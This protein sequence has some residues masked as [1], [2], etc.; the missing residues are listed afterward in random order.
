MPISWQLGFATATGFYGQ[1]ITALHNT[2]LPADYWRRPL[3]TSQQ[4]VR[5]PPALPYLCPATVTRLLPRS[6][7]EKGIRYQAGAVPATVR[8]TSGWAPH[9]TASGDYPFDNQRSGKA[10]HPAAQARRPARAHP[11]SALAADERRMRAPARPRP[12]GRP[13]GCF[14]PQFQRIFGFGPKI[15]MKLWTE[16]SPENLVRVDFQH[17]YLLL[18]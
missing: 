14:R 11:G 7:V 10:A 15:T 12:S 2:H 4:V 16:F 18:F 3:R 5:A 1:A 17:F 8:A 9:A 13:N 6:E